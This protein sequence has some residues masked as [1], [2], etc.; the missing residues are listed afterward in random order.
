MSA[1]SRTK[2]A[3]FERDVAKALFDRL[4]ITF[5]RNLSQ[6]QASGQGDLNADTPEWPFLI[7]CK[8]CTRPD[9]PGWRR[10]AVAAAKA[11]NMRPCVI[12]R[13][14]GGPIRVSVPFTALCD[15]WPADEWA[16]V[17]LEGFCLIAREIM[18]EPAGWVANDYTALHRQIVGAVSE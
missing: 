12:Y 18:A 8:H 2:G 5:K 14:T 9:L 17:S 16:D 1:M 6:Y 11:A 7:E 15:A 4:G 3:Q 13:I 10:Q